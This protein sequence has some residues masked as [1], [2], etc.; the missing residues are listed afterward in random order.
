MR[1]FIGLLAVMGLALLSLA[2]MASASSNLPNGATITGTGTGVDLGGFIN[3]ESTVRGTVFNKP[4]GQ[5]IHGII[6][7]ATFGPGCTPAGSTATATGLPWTLDV[8][9]STNSGSTWDGVVTDVNVDLL[10]FGQQCR[11]TGNV[12]ALYEN[13]TM[14]LTLSG[15]L[16]RQAGSGL[17]CP[18]NGTVSGIYHISPTLT[19]S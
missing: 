16:T 17:L 1:K 9:G 13:T 4:A 5:G 7:S 11:F 12:G 3:C 8:T 18:E 15:S 19:I 10:V 14:Q 2:G 6:H